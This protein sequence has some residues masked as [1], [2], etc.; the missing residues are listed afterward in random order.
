[1]RHAKLR[2]PQ[3]GY[4]IESTER[5]VASRIPY[6][7][8]QGKGHLPAIE[9]DPGIFA[10]ELIGWLKGPGRRATASVQDAVR[11]LYMFYVA[12]ATQ[13]MPPAPIDGMGGMGG[14]GIGGPD[15]SAP[16]GTPN[17]PGRIQEPGRGGSIMQEAGQQVG[18]ADRQAEQAARVTTQREG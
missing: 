4:D 2:L 3:S 12:W 15:Q 7:I 13:G 17:R 5:A 18:T 9:D 1:M 8:E 14:S 6:L 10:E 16:G 11:Q